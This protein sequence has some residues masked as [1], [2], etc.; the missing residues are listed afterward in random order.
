MKLVFMQTLVEKVQEAKT[1]GEVSLMNWA[2]NDFGDSVIN[3]INSLITTAQKIAPAAFAICCI[4]AGFLFFA[5]R[6]GAD[7]AKPWILYLI[8]G[9]AFIFGAISFADFAKTSTQF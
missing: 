7:T 4:G 6:K 3:G 8:I 5:G 1:I 9:M 2:L